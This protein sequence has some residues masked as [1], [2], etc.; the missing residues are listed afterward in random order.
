MENK[1]LHETLNELIDENHNNVLAN[2]PV[3][4]EAAQEI[5]EDAENTSD[6]EDADKWLERMELLALAKASLSWVLKNHPDALKGILID[7]VIFAEE[8]GLET[9]D[10]LYSEDGM[11]GHFGD[12]PVIGPDF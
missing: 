9:I 11:E 7:S 5:S 12:E 10:D 4:H 8:I 3:L 6:P 1:P 2:A